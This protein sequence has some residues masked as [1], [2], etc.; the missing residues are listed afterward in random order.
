MGLCLYGSRAGA[1]VRLGGQG[2]GKESP[3]Y[4]PSSGLARTQGTPSTGAASILLN[5]AHSAPLP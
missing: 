3:S 2:G 4:L 1:T 5:P